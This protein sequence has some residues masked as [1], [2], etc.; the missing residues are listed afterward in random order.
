MNISKGISFHKRE[1][2]NNDI[3]EAINLVKLT[4]NSLIGDGQKQL[5]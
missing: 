1:E 2:T 4:N 5:L 3:V